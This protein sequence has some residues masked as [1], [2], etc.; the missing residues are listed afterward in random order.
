MT[1][2]LVWYAAYGSNLW[3]ERFRYYLEGGTAPGSTTA[4]AG[5]RNPAPPLQTERSSCTNERFYAGESKKWHGGG[6]AFLATEPGDHE[7]LLRLYLITTE[8]FEDVFAQEN[9]LD[10]PIALDLDALADVGQLDV[11]DGWYGRLIDLGTHTD[12]RRIITFTAADPPPRN[13]P[14]A[15]YL[16]MIERGEASLAQ[17]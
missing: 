12:G 9:G 13:P 14:H 10:A 7:T 5:A 2:D 4:S 15:N 11:V 1:E 17:A 3:P 8:Q 16:A 6:V